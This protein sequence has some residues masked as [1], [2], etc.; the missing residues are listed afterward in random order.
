MVTMDE[1]FAVCSD[2]LRELNIGHSVQLAPF[3]DEFGFTYVDSFFVECERGDDFFLDDDARYSCAE[4]VNFEVN[5]SSSDTKTLSAASIMT[6]RQW[7]DDFLLGCF[8]SQRLDDRVP[9]L[10]PPSATTT[11]PPVTTGILPSAMVQNPPNT[12]SPVSSP[13]NRGVISSNEEDTSPIGLIVGVSVGAFIFLAVSGV[14]LFVFLCMKPA[15]KTPKEVQEFAVGNNASETGDQ[16]VA[17]N[18]APATPVDSF[19]YD[20]SHTPVV[21]AYATAFPM[22]G[23]LSQPTAV[24]ESAGIVSNRSGNDMNVTFK[25]QAQSII[26]PTSVSNQNAANRPDSIGVPNIHDD[27]ES[28]ITEAETRGSSDPSGIYSHERSVLEVIGGIYTEKNDHQSA[29]SGS[30]GQ[31]VDP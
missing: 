27:T 13:S 19:S 31:S 25:D 15:R 8:T 3:C 5:S 6:D 9:T 16:G 24:N 26:Q 12:G 22:P 30:A 23:S 10:S 7:R 29:G 21:P 28:A 17:Y 14:V 2:N 18:N 11:M 20:N 4:T 1:S